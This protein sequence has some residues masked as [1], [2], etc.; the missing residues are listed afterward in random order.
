MSLM[1]TQEAA[2]YLGVS[3]YFLERDR[4]E[5]PTVPV[6]YVG[7]RSPRYRQQDLDKFIQSQTRHNPED[8]LDRGNTR[9]VASLFDP[10]EVDSC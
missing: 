2:E 6:V 1:T 9:D 4:V 10:D 5:G 7:H 8:S 3:R